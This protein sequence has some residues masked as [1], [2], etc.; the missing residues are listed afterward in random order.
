MK[1]KNMQIIYS[2][3][4][5]HWNVNTYLMLGITKLIRCRFAGSGARIHYFPDVFG[6]IRS[7]SI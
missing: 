2:T 6:G 4:L 5:A 7:E 1:K 3:L